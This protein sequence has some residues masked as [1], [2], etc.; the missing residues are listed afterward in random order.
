MALTLSFQDVGV[1]SGKRSGNRKRI[2]EMV[3]KMVQD[4]YYGYL[5]QEKQYIRM[6]KTSP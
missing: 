1:Q 2:K 3:V 5:D 4:N 6:L